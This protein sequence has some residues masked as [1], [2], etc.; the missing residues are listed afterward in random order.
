MNEVP[1]DMPGADALA[2]L[3]S[4][5]D[6]LKMAGAAGLGAAIGSNIV[7][8]Q[9]FALDPTGPTDPSF[10]FS[11]TSSYHPFD[12]ISDKFGDSV[13]F[14][15]QGSYT[16]LE[17]APEGL[18]GSVATG[19]GAL[20]VSSDSPFFALLQTNETPLAPYAAVIVDFGSFIGSATNE[21]TV[22]TGLIKDASN[23]I[24]AWYNNAT[25]RVGIDAV[26]GGT[27]NTLVERDAVPD[28]DDSKRFAFVL[29]SKEVTALANT[30]NPEVT[31]TGSEWEP[32]ANFPNPTEVSGDPAITPGLSQYV[33]LR[34]PAVLAQYKYGFGVRGDGGTIV[35]DGVETGYWGRAGV[36]DPHVVTWADG[37]PYIK[38]NKLYL[39]LTNAGLDFFA[40]AHWGVYTLDLSNYTS[41]NALEEVGKIFFKRGGKVFGDHAGHIVY[42]GKGNFLIG[43]STWGDFT[44]Q[45]V[46]VNYTRVKRDVLHGVHVLEATKLPLPAPL[47]NPNI[48]PSYPS[49]WDPHFTRIKR[50]WYVAY[51]ESPS[52]GGANWDHHP[53]L[54]RGGVNAGLSDL[55]L[56]GRDAPLN[57]TE[58]MVIQKVGHTWYV[59]CVSGE[60][61]RGGL[62]KKYRIYDLNM[63]FLGYLNADF[64]SNIP[65]PM[66]NPLPVGGNTKWIMLTFDGTD[67]Y[68]WTG[69][70]PLDYGTHGKFYV[71]DGP[72]WDGY[73]EFPPRKP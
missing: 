18:S 47:R 66:I 28:L 39:T 54:A 19:D 36:R 48:E 20:S 63:E 69:P 60:D 13:D 71:M 68:G 3:S 4:R 23:Y 57:Q 38:D 44:Y 50:R 56:V 32:L 9:A 65:H 33:D 14:A 64:T 11:T 40:T 34:D 61:E 55:T 46:Q 7:L 24:V 70:E 41:P 67:F 42:E 21:D 35:L 16:V 22:Y 15:S 45:G 10:R 31:G 8:R 37:T 43:V 51:V 53:A 17:P 30:G 72:T 27:V 29:N 1:A 6:F 58:G 62:P 5:R 73:Y 25:K 26:V 52:Q 2:Q 49:T 12:V 59:L